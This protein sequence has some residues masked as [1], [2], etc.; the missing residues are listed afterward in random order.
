VLDRVN[1]DATATFLK[2][3]H[4]DLERVDAKLQPLNDD[5]RSSI[6]LRRL[7][8]WSSAL[9]TAC[10]S[11]ADKQQS[12][13]ARLWP[14]LVAAL[15]NVGLDCLVIHAT[16]SATALPYVVRQLRSL[17][18]LWLDPDVFP[19]P[20]QDATVLEILSSAFGANTTLQRVRLVGPEDGP[21]S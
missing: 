7:E 16:V 3:I 19:N 6:T 15:A 8:L 13:D 1:T 12:M 2:I 11:I 9:P 4:P 21:Q 14:L 20:A 5:L 18:T 17:R 10:R